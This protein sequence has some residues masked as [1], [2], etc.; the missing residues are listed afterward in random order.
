MDLVSQLPVVY[1]AHS[2][3]SF[4]CRDVICEFV[5]RSGAV[6][7]NP[8]RMFEYFLN[9]RVERDLVRRG[10]N[11]IVRIADETWV[12]GDISDGVLFEIEYA[13]RL[14]KPVRY[15]S[16]GTE[17]RDIKEIDVDEA[18]FEA[19]ALEG[20]RRSEDELRRMMRS[21]SHPQTCLAELPPS[22]A[23]ERSMI[24]RMVERPVYLNFLDRE[25][26]EAV[27]FRLSHPVMEHALKCLLLG[28]A[29]P[30]YCGISLVWEN[31]GLAESSRRILASATQAGALHPVSYKAS[32]EEFYESRRLLYAHD[33]DRYPMYFRGNLQALDAIRPAV[34]KEDGTTEKISEQMLLWSM[35]RGQ[36]ADEAERIAKESSLQSLLTREEEAIT[37]AYFNRHLRRIS[38]PPTA[39][40]V[41][42]RQISTAY[43]T[44]YLDFYN[45]V[46]PTGLRGLEVFDMMLSEDF[47]LYDVQLLELLLAKFGLGALV[48]A[49]WEA[50]EDDWDAFLAMRGS[51]SHL[52][53]CGLIRLILRTL[54]T[55]AQGFGGSQFSLRSYVQ[56]VIRRIDVEP[57]PRPERPDLRIASAEI[58]AEA[59][60]QTIEHNP[61]YGAIMA[62]HRRELMDERA[63]ILLVTATR[64]ETRAVLDA[65]G[66]RSGDRL[67]RR[68]IGDNTYL[69]LNILSGAHVYLVETEMGSGGA[70]GSALTIAEGIQALRPKSLVMVGI[71]FG[72]DPARQR[73]GDVLVSKQVL[74]YEL[75]RRSGSQDRRTVLRGDRIS[76]SPRLLGRCRSAAVDWDQGSVDFGLV[77]SGDKL[78]DDVDFRDELAALTDGQA[79]GGEMEGAGL[80]AAAYRGKTDWILI[81][82]VCDWADGRK[83]Y[84]KESRQK[85][86]ARKAASFAHHMIEAGG[87]V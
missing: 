42:R 47:P 85:E 35:N 22:R 84:R 9:D 45:G 86:A 23:E 67:R 2:K 38:A 43:S 82:A 68:F 51:E 3:L 57:D 53:L 49:P 78:V 62:Q 10:N 28:T 76:A 55:T 31:T 64:T 5:L 61:Y 18:A 11:N 13:L 26:G 71:A 7:L 1:T 16:L 20:G 70:S 15:F 25:L 41:V 14:E 27:R 63:D 81:K 54:A 17:L 4:Y 72:L 40:A 48:S 30:L 24:G 34:I 29:S 37:I 50:A 80:C 73:I 79:I 56:S 32:V 77:M 52:R 33:E 58:A 8:F 19:G 21:A 59:M 65:F 46:V 60:A 66:I 75:Q 87:M 39:A 44:H 12:F 36:A 74:S 83:G 69:D 6:P